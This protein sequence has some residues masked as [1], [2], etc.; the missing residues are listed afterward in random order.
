VF[1]AYG[2]EERITAHDQSTGEKAPNQRDG[3][4]RSGEEKPKR[5]DRSG[6]AA[7]LAEERKARAIIA[8]KAGDGSGRVRW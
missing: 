8:Q 7:K 2:A 6:C 3:K 1:R 5:T 4:A